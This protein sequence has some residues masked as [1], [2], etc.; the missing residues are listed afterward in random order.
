MP[1][2]RSPLTTEDETPANKRRIAPP[3]GT[4]GGFAVRVIVTIFLAGIALLLWSLRDVVLLL[5][6]ATLIAVILR[7]AANGLRRAIPLGEG[8]SLIVAGVLILAVIGL[9]A[10]VFGQ[11]VSRQVTQLGSVLPA[12][13][14]DFQAWLVDHG[15]EMN[16]QNW[17][18]DGPM[19]AGWLQSLMSMTTAVLT[20]LVLAIVGGV[21]LAIKPQSYVEGTLRL[22]PRS[23]RGAVG[24]FFHYSGRSLRRWLL[25]RLVAMLLIGLITY[26]GLLVIGVPSALALGI[27]AGFLE[28]VPFAG[29]ILSAVPA[30]LLALTIDFH[31]FLLTLGLYILVQQIEGNLLT[32]L[33]LDRAV[34][35]PPALT[36]FSLFLFGALFGVVGVLLAGPLTV[37]AFIA[38]KT[39]W[40]DRTLKE[41]VDY[42]AES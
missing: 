34:D 15:I 31:T 4:L 42:A 22:L 29:P 25:A 37:V 12:A 28:F 33:L 41:D 9:A 19:I 35:L 36:L 18:P 16:T 23:A 17:V 20:G 11:E 26:L 7:A 30:L 14:E 40:M 39:L 27:I 6:A 32:P 3:A 24:D 21:Y 1:A 13:W 10:A 8:L 38:V 5:F 2:T